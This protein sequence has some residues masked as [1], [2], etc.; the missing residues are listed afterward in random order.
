MFAGVQAPRTPSFNEADVSDKPPDV[1]NLPLL[2]ATQ[3]AAI[4]REYQT[5]IESLQA[6]DEGIGQIIDTLAARGEL[7]NTYV[8]FTSDNGY[9]LGQH[10][11]LGSKFQVYEEDIRVPLII[12]GPGVEAGATRDQ[13]A[14]N[15]DLAP[16]IAR[17]GRATPDRVMDGLSLTPLLG[18]GGAAQNWR[19][20][21]LV[22]LYRHLPPAQNGDVIK[23]LRTEHEVYV[24]YQSGPR[25]LYD[26]RSDPDQL[27]NIYTTADPSHIADLSAQLAELA[28]SQG[29][30]F[31]PGDFNLDGIVDT[32]DYVVWRKGLGTTYTQTD[33]DVWRANFG[34]ASAGNGAGSSA[35][36]PHA[37]VPASAAPLSAAVPESATPALEGETTARDEVFSTLSPPRGFGHE[38]RSL[39]VPFGRELSAQ[40]KP[41]NDKDLL[42]L[43]QGNVRRGRDFLRGWL[44]PSMP[45]GEDGDQ[46]TLERSFDEA[47]GTAGTGSSIVKTTIRHGSLRPSSTLTRL[48]QP[49]VD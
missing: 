16:T 9:H 31:L 24:E 36:D 13:M 22:E 10:R 49:A 26:L 29:P 34:A 1:R 37:R 33:Y 11:F 45:V 15:I 2:T 47:F 3:I 35:G 30:P 17:W 8:V 42:A 32:V 6:L 43:S 5:R 39:F 18:S 28:T 12:R 46:G 48:S 41:P 40:P 38:P 44:P 14:V 21:F 23:A 4:D 7:E 19:T 27:Q 25:E 20:D